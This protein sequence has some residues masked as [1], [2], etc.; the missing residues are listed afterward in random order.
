MNH[1][2]VPL[3]LKT[4]ASKDYAL[5]DSGNGK[6]LERYGPY[7]LIRPEAQALWQPFLPHKE[8]Q[9]VDAIFTGNLDEE[10]AGRWSFPKKPLEESWAMQW[11]QLPFYG[12]F[13]SF[14]HVG[15]FPEQDAHWRFLQSLL[16]E[17]T[18][19]KVLNLFG[20]TGIASLI[21]AQNNAHVTNVDA[22]KKAIN[23]AKENQ[24][25][26]G[27]TKKPI[28]W[29]CED[30]MKFVLREERRKNSY[31][32]I[33]LDPPAY[34]RGTHNEVWKFFDDIAQML[35]TCSRILSPQACGVILTSYSIRASCFALHELMREVFSYRGGRI[36]SGELVLQAQ[37]NSHLLSTSLFS[38]WVST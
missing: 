29:I 34:G 4:K 20:Y 15:V 36:E 31:D 25:F 19:L 5:L 21:A 7:L 6:K 37:S 16:Q 30:A 11:Q 27:L 26:S 24:V 32:I 23:W 10:G 3:I 22:S 1:N 33:L 8:W 9:N 18:P 17:K 35:H 28:R 38:R 14:R 13:T 2:L 12:R